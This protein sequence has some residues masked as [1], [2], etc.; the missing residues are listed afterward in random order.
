MSRFTTYAIKEISSSFLL[1]IILISGI[2]W[3]GQGLR[4]IELMTSDNVS[5]ISYL[6]YVIL[7]LP[8]ILLLT[9]PICIFLSVLFNINRLRNDSELIVLWAAGKSDH[10]IFIKPVLFIALLVY[11]L[12]IILS[13]YITPISLNEIRH[14]IID[15]RSSGIHS[16]ILKEKKFISPVDTLTIFL[17]KREGNK[18]NGLLIHD[19]KDSNKPQTYIA[20]NGEFIDENNMKILRLYN[21]N[22]QIFESSQNKI[23]EI[24]FETYDLN[25]SPYSKEENKHIYSDELFTSQIILNLKGKK[26]REFNKYEKEQ[27]AE[28]HSRLANPLYIFCFALLPLLIIKFSRKPGDG[29]SIPITVISTIAFLIQITQITLVNFLITKSELIYFNYLFPLFIA[30]IIIFSIF[31]ENFHIKRFINV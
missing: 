24:E 29:Q 23:S 11:M 8:K 3:M 18:I 14:K 10:D 25:L 27:F 6:S 30:I 31:T 15:I 1:L 19:L 9:T 22:I 17:Q 5:F 7:L 4:H 12:S 28:L 26:M 2:L 13:V 20:Q 16:S 21:G